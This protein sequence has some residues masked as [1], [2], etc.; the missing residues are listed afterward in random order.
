MSDELAWKRVRS[1]LTEG[2]SEHLPVTIAWDELDEVIA[3]VVELATAGVRT[4]LDRQLEF[5]KDFNEIFHL[6]S[7]YTQAAWAAHANGDDEAAFGYLA[8]PL[9]GS[10]NCP[11]EGADPSWYA[12]DAWDRGDV[13]MPPENA[14]IN[15]PAP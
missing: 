5:R 12:S 14:T 6:V 7:R 4:E 3:K 13:P 9:V 8:A 10:G 1:Y 2:M 11:P 15:E